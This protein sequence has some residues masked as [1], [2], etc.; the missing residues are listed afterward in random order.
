MPDP[1]NVILVCPCCS[2]PVDAEGGPH[3]QD[4]VCHIC[5]QQWSMV[6]D[7][8]RVNIYSL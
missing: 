6:V 1:V 7:A 8:N 3:S 2:S 4:F 5:G